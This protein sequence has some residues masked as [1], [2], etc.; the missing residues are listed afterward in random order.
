MKDFLQN[1]VKNLVEHPDQ[2]VVNETED[3]AR[4]ILTISV[5]DEDMGRVIGKEGKVINAIRM[6][7]RV[8]AIRQDKRIR[9]DI[10]D[11]QTE[12]ES[13]PDQEPV[14]P[15]PVTQPQPEAAPEPVAAPAP[16]TPPTPAPEPKDSAT[17]PADIVGQPQTPAPS[18]TV[19]DNS[20]TPKAK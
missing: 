20:D 4:T 5:A 19:L 7:M 12:A 16:V 15:E 11:N 2:V 17:T 1:I 13:E 14:E 3:E 8:M 10:E 9:V 18:T 6:I